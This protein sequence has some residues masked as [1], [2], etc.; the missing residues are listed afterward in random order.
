VRVTKSATELG[1][2]FG[3]GKWLGLAC[4]DQRRGL[5][6]V[7]LERIARTRGTQVECRLERWLESSRILQSFDLRGGGGVRTLLKIG[8]D[9][10]FDRVRKL[11]PDK[12]TAVAGRE[13]E[14]C[15]GRA[16]ISPDDAIPVAQARVNVRW[17]VQGVWIGRRRCFIGASDVEPLVLASGYVVGVHQVVHRPGVTGVTLVH[18]Q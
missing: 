12:L 15:V 17:H 3:P 5:P 16:Q 13:S 6:V 7:S 11:V 18:A 2:R 14:R 9:E 10:V 4:F 1:D 8:I